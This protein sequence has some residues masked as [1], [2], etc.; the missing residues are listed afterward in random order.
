MDLYNHG[1][2][3]EEN[4]TSIPRP[5][6]SFSAVQVVVG[7]A[8]VH[9]AENTT[10]A[11]NKPI[12]ARTFD[13]AKKK[14]GY[15]DD[16]GKYTLCE[17][18][19]ASFK[20]FKVGPVVFINV[21]DPKI[22]KKSTAS[23][24]IPI[25]NKVARIDKDS[26]ILSSLVVKK[27]DGSTTYEKDKDYI[28]AYDKDGNLVISI[29][30][31][32]LI[33]SSETKLQVSFDEIDA[34]L[35][36]NN[37]IIGGY[38]DTNNMYKG[39]ELVKTVYPSLGIIPNTI[40]A[41]GF[42]HHA[43][44]GA[45]LVAKSIKINGCFNA[46]NVIDVLGKTKETAIE[47]KVINEYNDKTSVIC[48]PKSKIGNKVYHYST[49]VAAAIAKRDSQNENVPFKSPSNLKIPISAM[50]NDDGEEVF[51]DQLEGNVL[52]GQ[53]IV[54]AINMGGWRTWG[55]NTAAY[56]PEDPEFNDPKDRFIAVR[57]MF[58]WW[59]NTF[60]QEY[61]DKVDDA[62]NYRL[63]ESLVDSE[64]IRANGFK[65]KGQIAGG[66]IE[67]RKSDNPVNQILNGK[68]QFIQKVAFFTPA[69]SITNILEF[70]PT[71]LAGSIIGGE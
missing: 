32:G 18:M 4:Q 17:V 71:I 63:I 42:S 6:E 61:F 68:I 52:N 36:K 43:E 47:N 62:T 12:I 44:V 37:D 9:L 45:I 49:I 10:E 20:V 57:R 41:P 53:G 54:T 33:A 59:G 2:S 65:A 58:D 55:N 24:E 31:S 8:P 16:W 64:N 11:I 67:F 14:L 19:D 50:V 3:L 7:T 66:K 15:S 46:T 70:D 48:W 13:E 56:N 40:I 69:E 22:H 1:F 38:D 60:I 39:L 51:L 35:V 34:S 5:E 25:M 29:L 27:S 21:L 23:I 30:A 26:I 28:S